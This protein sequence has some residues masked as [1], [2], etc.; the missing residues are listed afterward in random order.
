MVATWVFFSFL[1]LYAKWMPFPSNSN[2]PNR[3]I[4]H[5]QDVFNSDL[6]VFRFRRW[7]QSFIM[8]SFSVHFQMLDGAFTML[9]V[10][11][12]SSIVVQIH[13][14]I[15]NTKY[16]LE[17]Q[18]QLNRSSR[19]TD[20]HLFRYSRPLQNRFLT[21]T[22]IRN[23]KINQPTNKQKKERPLCFHTPTTWGK[24]EGNNENENQTNEYC[25]FLVEKYF[26]KILLTWN[27][28]YVFLLFFFV[29]C[30]LGLVIC[31]L[32]KTVR[33]LVCR[34]LDLFNKNSFTQ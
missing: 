25:Y 29:F 27:W 22:I 30:S 23:P 10:A 15:N 4:N 20:F 8:S 34:N 26:N 6:F 19:K 2:L 11:D 31:F 17:Q 12:V 21:N 16:R 7:H 5:L 33:L 9:A 24:N 13:M 1:A 3:D 28:F 32:S 18:V 14:I